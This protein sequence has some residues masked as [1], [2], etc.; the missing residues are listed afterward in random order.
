VAGF[1]GA[2]KRRRETKETAGRRKG[3]SREDK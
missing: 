1:E 2:R 3:E